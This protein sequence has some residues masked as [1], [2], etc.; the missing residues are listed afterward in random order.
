M[1]RVSESWVSTHRHWSGLG[2]AYLD[3]LF[4][5]GR[6]LH[7]LPGHPEAAFQ[8]RVLDLLLQQ[9]HQIPQGEQHPENQEGAVFLL[10]RHEQT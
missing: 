4:R 9:G 6:D 8:A 10:H 3:K 2:G 7:F 1:T 5:R